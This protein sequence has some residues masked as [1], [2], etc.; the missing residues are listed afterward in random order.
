M[1]RAGLAGN[2]DA[3]L[4]IDRVAHGGERGEHGAGILALEQRPAAAPAHAIDQRGDIDL[5]GYAELFYQL[6]SYGFV[7]AAPDS[8]DVGCTD[9]SGGA[10][11]TT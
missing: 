2:A 8:C 10:P 5:L 7:V 11:W 9:P 3:G 6:A 4:R 1:M